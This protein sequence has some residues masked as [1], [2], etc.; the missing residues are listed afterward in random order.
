MSTRIQI[1]KDGVITVVKTAND[2]QLALNSLVSTMT[3]NRV[4]RSNGTNIVLSQIDLSTDI[5][6]GV[7][8]PA[9]GG[10]GNSAS[11]V[12]LT[13]NQTIGGTKTFSDGLVL[14]T[15][16]HTSIGAIWRNGAN[17]EF[18]NN[19]NTTQIILNSAGNLSN[20]SDKQASLN[21]L[22]GTQTANSVLRSDGTNVTLSLVNL[23]T[24]TTNVLPTAS[25]GTGSSTQNW[26]DL[27]TAQSIGGNK[28]FTGTVSGITP[29]M[30]S[31][32]NVVNS[33]Q[34]VASNNLS[35]LVSR[36]TAL[37]NISGGITSGTYLRGNGTNI[38]LSAIQATDVPT[39]NQNTSG[40]AS[41]VTGVVTIA[42]GGTGSSTQNFVDLSSAQTIAGAKT[43]S[44]LLSFS[45]TTNATSTT[46]A[47]VTFLGGVGVSGNVFIGG[48]TSLGDNVAI[49]TK[50][51]TGT[52]GA[53]Q[54]GY[55]QVN[56]GITG[57]IIGVQ[58]TVQNGGAG[59]GAMTPGFT[60]TSS[61]LE[62]YAY[63]TSTQFVIY[64]HTTNSGSIVGKPYNAIITYKA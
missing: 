34:L 27:T 23:A 36:Q 53:T 48:F 54:G 4:L 30:V 22:V 42:N 10:S 56:H 19:A 16:V 39:L 47:S 57:T 49:K 9:N 6:T 32:G 7:L 13:T 52:V 43:F 12:D 18:R 40:T 41:N 58:S 51:I 26:V 14:P 8:P 37:N 50:L 31:L 2:K 60:V 25:G 15:S 1:L 5:I 44:S 45:N 35:D 61:G 46:S 59:V 55:T 3:A 28:T 24:D 29:T 20:L 64:T 63:T 38:I 11:Y 62:Y 17:L 21:N 33:L